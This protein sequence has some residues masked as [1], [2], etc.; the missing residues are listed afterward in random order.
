M[1]LV[2]LGSL[3][4]RLVN[5]PVS[6]LVHITCW[7]SQYRVFTTESHVTW[8]NHEWQWFD[9]VFS[10]R[11]QA[12]RSLKETMEDCWDQDAEARL[13][14]QCAEERMA[15]LL[16][17]WERNK[18]VSPT[19]NP[20][21]TALQNERS[22]HLTHAHGH[23]WPAHEWMKGKCA[24]HTLKCSWMGFLSFDNFFFCHAL[25]HF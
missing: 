5:H 9:C 19:I 11:S 6:T 13:T 18:P 7:S 15:E 4:V 1:N 12:V 8:W 22:D 23:C 10:P 3:L 24:Y 20:M 17:I 25:G 16:L 2:N 21:S 14:A